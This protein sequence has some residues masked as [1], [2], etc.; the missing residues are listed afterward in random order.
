MSTVTLQLGQCGNQLGQS[1][2]DRLHS[3][4][5]K[6]RNPDYAATIARQ[7]FDRGR[8]RAVLLDMEP[9]V[10][11]ACLGSGKRSSSKTFNGSNN[12]LSSSLNFDDLM[13]YSHSDNEFGN[14]LWF[15]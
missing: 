10:I 6:T 3:E 15:S 14:M 11:Q 4:I 7:F 5:Q 8:A 1:L 9:R 13:S 2:F 12:N